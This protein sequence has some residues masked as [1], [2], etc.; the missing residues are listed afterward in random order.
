M[1]I[2]L[3][4]TIDKYGKLRHSEGGLDAGAMLNDLPWFNT[5][6]DMLPST[7]APAVFSIDKT[8]PPMTHA[9]LRKFICDEVNFRQHGVGRNDR[10]AILFPNGPELA[11]AFIAVLSYC[12]SA[13]LNPASTPLEIKGELENVN[14]RALMVM[15]GEDNDGILEVAEQLDLAVIECTVDKSVAGLFAM[16][17]PFVGRSGTSSRDIVRAGAS[18]GNDRWGPQERPD[19]AMV[20][21]TSGSTGNKKVVPHTVEDLLVGAITIASACQLSPTDICCNQMPLFHVGGIARNVLSPILSGGSVVAMPYFEPS[22]F[23]GVVRDFTCTWYYAGPTM[24]MLILESYKAFPK[25]RP[26]ISLRFIANA[27]GPLLPSVAEDMRDTYSKAAG[28]FCS[29]MPSYGMTECMPISSPPVGYNLDRPGTSGQIVGPRCSIRDG[30]T[31]EALPLGTTGDIF[32]AGHPVMKAYENNPEE[33]AKN[34]FGEWFNTGD[35]GYLDADNY[36][37]LTGRSKEVINRGGEI[38]APTDIE[39]AML[40][41]AHIKNLVAFSTPHKLLQETI[42][43]CVVSAPGCPRVG[44]AGMQAHASRTLHPSK[45]PQLIV[46]ASDIPKTSTGKAMRVRL[47]KRMDLPEISDDTPERERL[48]EAEMLKPGA[49]VQAPIP[50]APL[51]INPADT[52]AAIKAQ[53]GVADVFVATRE[54]DKQPQLVAFVAPQEVDAEALLDA[55]ATSLHEYLVP[56]LIKSLASVPRAADGSVAEDALPQVSTARVCVAPRTEV[57]K[58]VQAIWC[59]LLHVAETDASMDSDFFLCGGTSLLAGTFAGE[60]KKAFSLPLSGT[61][62]FKMRTIEAIAAAVEQHNKQNEVQDSLEPREMPGR[63]PHFMGLIGALRGSHGGSQSHLPTGGGGDAE[64]VGAEPKQMQPVSQDSFLPLV[65]QALPLILFHPIRRIFSWALFIFLWVTFLNAPP[66]LLLYRDENA[67]IYDWV[68]SAAAADDLEP[69]QAALVQLIHSGFAVAGDFASRRFFVMLGALAVL[70]CARSLAFPLLG[71]LT[72]WLVIGRYRAGR[73]RLWGSYYL[74]WWFV[75]QT[76]RFCGRGVFDLNDAL[77]CRYYKLLGARVGHG[78]KIHETCALSEADLVSIGDGTCLDAH[79]IVSPFCADAGA[80]MLS[81][82]EIG[83]RCAICSRTVIAPGATV[84]D[85]TCL[86]PLSSSHEQGDASEAMRKYCRVGF[87]PPPLHLSLLLGLPCALFVQTAKLCLPLVTIFVMVTYVREDDPLSWSSAIDWFLSPTRL[88]L[89]FAIRLER[90]LLCPFLELFAVIVVKRVVVGKFRPGKRTAWGRFQYATMRGLLKDGTLCGVPYLIGNHWEGVSF[91]LRMLGATCGQRIFWPGSGIDVVE[92][93]LIEIQ[94][95]CV[96]GS[97]SLFYC[98]SAENSA[99]IKLMRGS[100]V[101]DRCVVLPGVTLGVN[102]C[103]GSGSLAA[104]GSTFG[105][106]CVTVGSIGGGTDVLDEGGPLDA[107]PETKTVKPFSSA[108][109]GTRNQRKIAAGAI[110]NTAKWCVP[111]VWLYV[112]Y[113]WFCIAFTALYRSSQIVLSWFLVELWHRRDPLLVLKPG[114]YIHTPPAPPPTLPFKP[115]P[116]NVTDGEGD[117]LSYD[118]FD[119]PSRAELFDENVIPTRTLNTWNGFGLYVGSLLALYIAVHTVAT[120]LAYLL[121]ILAKWLWLGRRRAGTFRWDESSYCMRWNC[122][123]TTCVI[124]RGLLAYLQGS[125]YLVWYFRALGCDIG[126]DVCLYPT[127]SDPM[128]TEPDLVTIRDRAVLNHAFVICHTNTKG[129][130]S[131]NTITIEE[132]ATM[133]SWSRLMAGATLS[134]KA[135][136]LEHTLA[137]VGDKVDTGMIWQ[138][139]PCVTMK[140]TKEYWRARRAGVKFGRKQWKA[141]LSSTPQPMQPIIIHQSGGS[142]GDDSAHSHTQLSRIAE[143]SEEDRKRLGEL[144]EEMSALRAENLKLTSVLSMHAEGK[145]GAEIAVKEFSLKLD[146][147]LDSFMA[148]MRSLVMQQ[149]LAH[150]GRAPSQQST[151]FADTPVG[152]GPGGTATPA[153]QAPSLSRQGSASRQ[154]ALAESRQGSLVSSSGRNSSERRLLSRNASSLTSNRTTLQRSSDRSSSFRTSAFV[155]VGPFPSA[156]DRQ[157]SGSSRHSASALGMIS[158]C[159]AS[160]EDARALLDEDSETGT[161]VSAHD[162]DVAERV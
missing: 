140:T 66:I 73:S 47:D 68:A 116:P 2:P 40:S 149:S 9:R 51:V 124:R 8:R 133:R 75:H 151:S 36:L 14:A 48:F 20:L 91:F 120:V 35:K 57:E 46:Y 114:I 97:R 63:F 129:A 125:A 132:G 92:H 121:E 89:Y 28:G 119:K 18:N 109:Y 17:K 78:I 162:Q 31:G 86:G 82:I 122:Y 55:L 128:M 100:N 150:H 19:C 135:R 80:M 115:L 123:L 74:R 130:Y 157:Q 72:K 105:S 67:T 102:G 39:E 32:V 24:H 60:I 112:C 5:I 83:D 118:E 7:D 159:V 1:S 21:H 106:G 27:A 138:G 62:L 56:V 108:F 154:G 76:L 147:K 148:E 84:A 42:G 113:G 53:P 155:A 16:G 87:K 23:W 134:A 64:G 10:V 44:L 136:L 43:V 6:L 81:A 49:P 126:E 153:S 101:A 95:D 26:T 117:I 69:H 139:W 58:K 144:A 90:V 59:E 30:A 65:V 38:I 70:H 96:F 33:T 41:H 79:T 104:E 45:W 111:P 13:P 158:A 3:S 107:T 143:R 160:T 15:A 54:V 142:I 93:D 88:L 137:L 146:L 25:P 77:R 145:S 141:R 22:F 161:P 4:T 12:T 34:F 71:I 61:A 29:I 103:L 85:D 98:S 94:D 110:P 127:G 156:I 152:S 11:V 99:P 52:E 131:L 50:T 37:Y